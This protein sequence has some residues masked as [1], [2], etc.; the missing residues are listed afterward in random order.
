MMDRPAL[1]AIWPPTAAVAALA[2][3]NP[4]SPMQAIREKCLDCTGYQPSE[5]ARCESVICP[6]W[7]FRAGKHPYTASALK[8]A[9]LDASFEKTGAVEGE[10]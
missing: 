3:H 2:G 6:L 8:K 7:P 4:K 5:V 10:S 9:A 1:A